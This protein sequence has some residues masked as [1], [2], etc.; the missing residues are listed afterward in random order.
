MECKVCDGLLRPCRD[1]DDDAW[2]CD[3]CGARHADKG[4][5]LLTGWAIAE[6]KL[7]K[8]ELAAA[9]ERL[10]VM[11]RDHNELGCSIA[12]ALDWSAEGEPFADIIRRD[13]AELRRFRKDYEL[14]EEI[15]PPDV[16]RRQFVR[17]CFEAWEK[18]AD[19]AAEG[20]E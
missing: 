6:I 17:W 11:V 7:L 16:L 20:D 10:C 15:S 2:F 8:K 1:P 18:S 4:W 13:R 5:V 9:K 3:K 14:F 12:S 19:E